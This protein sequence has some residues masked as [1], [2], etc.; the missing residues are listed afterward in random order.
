[1]N[2]SRLS[3]RFNLISLMLRSLLLFITFHFNFSPN[4][5]RKGSENQFTMFGNESQSAL[6]V[7]IEKLTTPYSNL[8][9]WMHRCRW[10]SFRETFSIFHKRKV[11]ER[12]NRTKE[13]WESHLPKGSIRLD[14][15]DKREC[16]IRDQ[17]QMTLTFSPIAK[18]KMT[19]SIKSCDML[20][21]LR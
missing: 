2:P 19:W 3:C 18:W 6:N 20:N 14:N 12:E 15:T 9:K 13:A 11:K 7:M 17:V 16:S 1:M 5:S 8:N 10:Q 21:A 4:T